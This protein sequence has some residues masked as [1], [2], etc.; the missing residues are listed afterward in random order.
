[1]YFPEGQVVTAVVKTVSVAAPQM[2]DTYCVLLGAV[3]VVHTPLV[4]VVLVLPA[5]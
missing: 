4:P 1:M 3:Q 2:V 5:A